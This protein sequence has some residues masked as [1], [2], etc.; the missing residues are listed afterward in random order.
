MWLDELAELIESLKRRSVEH[1]DALR[2]NEALTRSALID[3]VLTALGWD[4]TDPAQV[5]PEYVTINGRI[6]YAMF[7]G[8]GDRPVMLVEAPQ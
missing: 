5:I 7:A 6:D 1:S 8:G 3:P 4:L 2:K